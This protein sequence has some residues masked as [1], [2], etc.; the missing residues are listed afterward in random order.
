MDLRGIV[1]F[2]IDGTLTPSGSTSSF[3]AGRL[4]NQ[5]DLDEAEDRYAHGEL[6]NKRVSEIDAAGWR[7]AEATT[8][9][10]WLDEL[11]VIAG[12][13]PVLSWCQSHRLEPVL[14]SL[15]WQPVGQSLARRYGFTTN[16][17]PRV[18]SSQSV[19]DGTVAE[20]FDEF[21]KRDRALQL[22]AERQVPVTRCCAIGDSRSDIPLFR[23][24]PNSLALNAGPAARA[25]ATSAVDTDDLV[26][27]LPWLERWQRGLDP[28]SS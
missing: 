12:V 24:L 18:G 2:D 9:E 17:G 10:R 8:I 23:A 20:H 3:L 5:R 28:W 14:A 19:Y 1:F 26:A 25:A 16:G 7:G 27:I 21:D 11:P 13:E 4:G 22:A 6:T 15:A